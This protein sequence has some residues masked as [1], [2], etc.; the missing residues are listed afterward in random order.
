[1][2]LDITILDDDDTPMQS[3]A[4]SAGLHHQLIT[5]TRSLNFEQ[6]IRI[7]DYYEDTDFSV[8][9]LPNLLNE[10]EQLQ[11]SLK[12]SHQVDLVSKIG[13]LLSEAIETGKRVSAISD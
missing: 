6:L 5:L 10:V 11:A 2:S 3:V 9:E 4:I 7:N 8:E 1:M 13:N 12:D